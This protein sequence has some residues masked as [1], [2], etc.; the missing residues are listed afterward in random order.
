LRSG[1]QGE[2]IPYSDLPGFERFYLEDS[3][4]IDIRSSEHELALDVEA[5]LTPSHPDFGE[6]NAGKMYRYRRVTIR[7]PNV[8]RID[9]IRPLILRPTRDPDGSID[10]GNI[11]FFMLERGSYRLGGEW[12]EVVVVGD[13]PVVGPASPTDADG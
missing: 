1:G 11:D 13:Q 12:G 5:V 9:W 3:Y 10:Y 4:V 6:P 2:A 8:R 7:F